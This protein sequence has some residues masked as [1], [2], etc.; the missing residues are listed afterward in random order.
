M[1][2]EALIIGITQYDCEALENFKTPAKDARGRSQRLW[3]GAG[4]KKK[5]MG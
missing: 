1:L 5:G 4:G 3:E 2:R